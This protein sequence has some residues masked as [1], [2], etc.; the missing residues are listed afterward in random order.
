MQFY[1]DLTQL[2]INMQI[3]YDRIQACIFPNQYEVVGKWILIFLMIP[4]EQNKIYFKVAQRIDFNID[5][6]NS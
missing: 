5:F 4:Y 2:G 3:P 1:Y 6:I